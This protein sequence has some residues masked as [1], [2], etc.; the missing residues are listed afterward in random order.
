MDLHRFKAGLRRY[1][2]QYAQD[3]RHPVTRLTHFIGIPM[4]VAS[5]PVA[6]LRPLAGAALFAGGWALQFIGHY[7]AE[8][9]DPSFFRDPLYLLVGPVWVSIELLQLLGIVQDTPPRQDANVGS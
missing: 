8:K 5:L 9:K 4:I 3:H 1:L 7:G 6:L 2:D